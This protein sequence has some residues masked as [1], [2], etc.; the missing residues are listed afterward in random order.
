MPKETFESAYALIHNSWS[1]SWNTDPPEPHWNGWYYL[2]MAVE[3]MGDLATTSEQKRLASYWGT[4]IGKAHQ[5][6]WER[7]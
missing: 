7:E 2:H 5:L 3:A 6:A 1:H 4:R